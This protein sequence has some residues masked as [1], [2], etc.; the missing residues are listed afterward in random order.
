MK[1]VFIVIGSIFLSF[2]V[3]FVA[4]FII[5]Y[6]SLDKLECKSSEGNITIMYSEDEIVAYTAN[7]IKYDLDKQKKVAENIGVDAYMEEFSIWF[8]TNTTGTCKRK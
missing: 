2:V 5:G 4:L 1:N 7:G 8:N 6:V 3:L